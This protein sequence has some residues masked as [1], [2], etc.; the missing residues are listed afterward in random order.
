LNVQNFEEEVA[1]QFERMNHI[2]KLEV[3]LIKYLPHHLLP[4]IISFLSQQFSQPIGI[5]DAPFG[6]EYVWT[7]CR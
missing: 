7:A 1:L 3:K 4:P 5:R 6:R 2:F